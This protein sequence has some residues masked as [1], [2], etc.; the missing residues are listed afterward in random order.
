MQTSQLKGIGT[1]MAKAKQG[2]AYYVLEFHQI[3]EAVLKK[4]KFGKPSNTTEETGCFRILW[5]IMV[6]MYAYVELSEEAGG[7][8]YA[9]NGVSF[10]WWS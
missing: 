5:G 10:P 1:N 6:I 9:C 8:L 7:G 4:K 3:K 2:Q